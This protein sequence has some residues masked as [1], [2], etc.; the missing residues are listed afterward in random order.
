MIVFFGCFGVYFLVFLWEAEAGLDLGGGRAERDVGDGSSWRDWGGKFETRVAE[1]AMFDFSGRERF[2]QVHKITDFSL[3]HTSVSR[4]D[5]NRFDFSQPAPTQTSC[6]AERAGPRIFALGLSFAWGEGTFQPFKFVSRAD[7]DW[8]GRLASLASPRPFSRTKEGLAYEYIS[9]CRQSAGHINSLA[10]APPMPGM[11]FSL[12]PALVLVLGLAFLLSAVGGERPPPPTPSASPRLVNGLYL[13]WLL[14]H[15]A[16]DDLL[17][18]V[19]QRLF[20]ERS[21]A[22][23]GATSVSA[24]TFHYPPTDCT[25]MGLSMGAYDFVVLGGGTILSACFVGVSL[26]GIRPLTPPHD[27]VV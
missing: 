7:S 26:Y 4:L 12:L 21:V 27:S 9:K 18:H 22:V 17:F 5:M 2:S 15:N 8:D 19:A 24:L 23:S 3:T 14:S 20:A 13:G 1:F 10:R 6:R 16:G 11:R 25:M